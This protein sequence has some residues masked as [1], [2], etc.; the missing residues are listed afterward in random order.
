MVGCYRGAPAQEIRR[1]RARQGKAGGGGS[2]ACA[3]EVRGAARRSGDRCVSNAQPNALRGAPRPVP[4]HPP[5]A[6][7]SAPHLGHAL[8]GVVQGLTGSGRHGGAGCEDHERQGGA[9]HGDHRARLP[10]GRVR[11]VGNRSRSVNSE[12]QTLIPRAAV[13]EEAREDGCRGMTVAPHLAFL[14]TGRSLEWREYACT[15]DFNQ[16][17]TH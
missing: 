12:A 8:N 4:P 2:W 1:R 10:G 14:D 16:I 5:A 7:N 13:C 3:S 9:A 15:S 11:G 17:C 6:C